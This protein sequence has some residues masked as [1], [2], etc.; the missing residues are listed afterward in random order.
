MTALSLKLIIFMI[1]CGRHMAHCCSCP[2]VP[3]SQ[4]SEKMTW[5]CSDPFNYIQSSS[6]FSCKCFTYPVETVMHLV[7]N[8]ATH[9]SMFN[10]TGNI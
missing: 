9:S 3:H 2:M 8:K 7:S 5:F 4:I 6:A 1:C 10:V